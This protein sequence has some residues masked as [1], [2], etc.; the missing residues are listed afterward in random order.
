MLMPDIVQ[1]GR[2]ERRL[3]PS[4][5]L[6]GII[7]NIRQFAL[8]LIFLFLTAGST[9]FGWQGWALIGAIPYAFV[10]LGRYIWFHYRL[11]ADEIV[12]RRGLVFRNER[13][14]PYRRIQNLDAVQN[15]LHRAFGVVELRLET[16]G[17]KEPEAT[18]R[19]VSIEAAEEI[20]RRVFAQRGAAEPVAAAAVEVAVT[21]PSR[22]R[23]LLHLPPRELMVF[24]LIENRGAVVIAAA[25]GFIWEAGL[26]DRFVAP[27]F[28]EDWSGGRLFRQ[29]ADAVA[30]QLVIT[31]GRVLLVLAAL[32][33]LLLFVRLFSVAWA[34]IRLYDFRLVREGEDLRSQFGLLTRVSATIPLRRV[35]TLTIS[36]G[37]LY[38]LARRAAVRVATAGGQGEQATS[39]QREWLAPIIRR[40]RVC[41]LAGEVIPGLNLDGLDW[42]PVDPRAFRRRVKVSLAVAAIVSLAVA[43]PLGRWALWFA[44]LLGT[45]AVI[46]ARQYVRH[47][48]W[49]VTDDV[50]A[51]RSGWLWREVTVGSFTRI[52]AVSIHES[53]FDRRATMARVRVDTA[54]AKPM[55]HRIDVPYLTRSVAAD[56][57]GRLA[58]EAARTSF[59]W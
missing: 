24:G 5:L 54:G 56:L 57:H 11:E 47:L 36:E 6:F 49:A 21:E 30:G 37:L 39:T 44:L 26:F 4:S 3:H 9:G 22:A 42:Q 48:G 29:A 58:M 38:R 40:E 41:S 32:V 28:G 20:R 27:W 59:R 43:A 31:A 50:V 13:H 7:A 53:P 25:L 45:L 14:V 34:F 12:V 10:S 46:H 17:G 33:A 35:Q 15:V 19:V 1:E 18:L 51:F 55:A 2:A 16:G 23:T 52:Q 8:P